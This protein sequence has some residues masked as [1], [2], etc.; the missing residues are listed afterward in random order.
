MSS[1]INFAKLA[2][3]IKSKRGNRG[4]RAIAEE[5][6]DISS[7]TLSRLEGERV[8]DLSSSNLLRLVDWLGVNLDEVVEHIDEGNPPELDTLDNIELQLRAAK[9]LDAKTAR[10]LAAMFR[11]AR[12]EMDQ[13]ASSDEDNQA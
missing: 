7:S 9:D 5:I 8:S 2:K 6:G 11:A 12:D 10:M 13:A 4:L 3:L 1:A